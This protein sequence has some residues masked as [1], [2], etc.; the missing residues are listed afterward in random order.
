MSELTKLQHFIGGER[1]EPASGQ[2]FDSTNPATRA[3]LYQAARGN[4]ADV[5]VA[6]ASASRTFEDPRWRDLS[7]TRRGHLLRRL[8]DLIAENADELA[9]MET[10][11]NGKLL[12]EMR[13]QLATP[14]HRARVRVVQLAQLIGERA[15]PRLECRACVAE[16]AQLRVDRR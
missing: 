14:I 3:T 12:R 4:A 6:V 8:A 16:A 13:G 11:D 9:R 7:Q 15:Q 5:D 1:V 10:R 2:Y